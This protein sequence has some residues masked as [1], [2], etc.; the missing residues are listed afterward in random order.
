MKK[1]NY[2]AVSPEGDT[3]GELSLLLYQ[4]QE[5][6]DP[7]VVV[8]LIYNI[9]ELTARDVI[10]VCNK[11]EIESLFTRYIILFELTNS[12]LK[13]IIHRMKMMKI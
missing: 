11:E 4:E 12:Q 6:L 3:A 5:T 2:L 10:A 8:V 13:Q 1:R 7:E 9:P